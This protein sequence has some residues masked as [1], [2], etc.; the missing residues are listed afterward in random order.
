MMKPVDFCTFSVGMEPATPMYVNCHKEIVL[1]FEQ[2]WFS[3]VVLFICTLQNVMETILN[4]VLV[5]FSTTIR[6]MICEFRGSVKVL[7]D[8]LGVH[9]NFF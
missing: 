3:A 5:N 1:Y 2:K 9:Q 4:K 7:K 6:S 8:H